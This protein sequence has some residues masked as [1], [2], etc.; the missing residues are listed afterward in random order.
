M[1]CRSEE[2]ALPDE[3]GF[4][5]QRRQHFHLATHLDDSRRADEYQRQATAPAG[6]VRARLEA[7]PLTAVRV[8]ADLD[9]QP[10]EAPL[11]GVTNAARREDEPGARGEDGPT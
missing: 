11:Y 9:V 1:E 4:A 8:A 6:L 7:F 10:A 5:G 3:D 2:S